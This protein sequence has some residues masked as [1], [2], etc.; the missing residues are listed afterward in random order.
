MHAPTTLIL[1]LASSLAL[2]A[3]PPFPNHHH[4]N[5]RPTRTRTR[6][7]FPFPRPTATGGG[8]GGLGSDC[9]GG[10]FDACV[11]SVKCVQ[12]WPPLSF[13]F[14]R[15]FVFS[16]F[17]SPPSLTT[18]THPQVW[19]QSC[20]CANANT[21]RCAEA[22]RVPVPQTQTCEELAPETVPKPEP[23]PK[24]EPVCECDPQMAW[25]VYSLPFSSPFLSPGG[26]C[27]MMADRCVWGG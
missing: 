25:Y 24:P 19:P 26:D 9:T 1:L 13:L 18:N 17:L 2:A 8:G 21:I 7:R 27:E 10:T 6:T 20:H 4:H 3:P 16:F 15:F 11:N 22:C 14:F 5:I 23:E 12:V